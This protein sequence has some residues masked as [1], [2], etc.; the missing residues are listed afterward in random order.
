MY[1]LVMTVGWEGNMRK[2][3][4]T[5]EKLDSFLDE[6]SVS[7]VDFEAEGLPSSTKF[8]I[9]PLMGEILP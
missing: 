8:E 1:R 2:L 5:R 7:H 6:D 3:G 4:I 9:E